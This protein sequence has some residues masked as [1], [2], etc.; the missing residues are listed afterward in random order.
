M[1]AAVPQARKASLARFL[2]K[3][4]ERWVCHV[5]LISFIRIVSYLM[6]Y[7]HWIISLILYLI[8]SNAWPITLRTIPSFFREFI[9]FQAWYFVLNEDHDIFMLFLLRCKQGPFPK[10]FFL[11]NYIRNITLGAKWR[12]WHIYFLVYLGISPIHP[13]E[14]SVAWLACSISGWPVSCPILVQR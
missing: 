3:R 6:S 12:P 4:K 1:S 8:W 7:V 2:E 14:R 5:H 10:F 11:W 13:R 9:S